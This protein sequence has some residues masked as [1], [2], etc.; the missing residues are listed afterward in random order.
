MRFK[1]PSPSMMVASI[2]LFVSLGGTSLA[3]VNYAQKAGK[4]DGRDAVAADSTLSQAAGNLVA[5]RK[6]GDNKGRIPNKFLG[7]AP[8]VKSFEIRLDVADNQPG[9]PA[10]LI[11]SGSLGTLSAQCS[12]QSEAVGVE[13]PIVNLAWANG[14]TVPINIARR[15]GSAGVAVES[16]APGAQAPMQVPVQN[17][18]LYFVQL[19]TANVMV[20]GMAR[21]EGAGTA[22]G[23]CFV[24]GALN[25]I[26]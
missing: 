3:A 24:S 5:T 19:G 8:F 26:D 9:A 6:K 21:Q 7:S 2:A 15:G 23:T 13:N 4:V 16:L 17:T 10:T 25:R 20:N 22:A 1:R 12:D 11:S 18:F 14:S